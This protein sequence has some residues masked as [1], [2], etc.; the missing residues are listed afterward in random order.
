MAD[1]RTH[2]LQD[3]QALLNDREVMRALISASDAD[4][5]NNIIDLKSVVLKRLEGRLDEMEGQNSTIISAAY[6]NINTTTQVHRAI[7]NVLEP[8]SFTEFLD[9]LRGAWAQTVNV[10]VA[11][12][13]L[14]APAIPLDDMPALQREFGPGVVFLQ[15]DEIDYYITLGKDFEPRP[16][17]LR[18]I[19]KGVTKI[20]GTHAEG[21]RSEALMK[22]NLG[23]GN[24]PG[25]LLLG[26]NDATKFA[27]NMGTELLM[28]YGSVFEKVM[29][30]W[31][32]DD[33]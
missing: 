19:R 12:V 4:A 10:D 13:C 20:H 24:R 3:P 29:Q 15:R 9:F 25:L 14:E 30:R 5:S 21:V 32:Y 17:T 33:E 7:L 18:Q 23:A 31:L 1:I 16:I 8:K 11:R 22:L 26:S 27:P 2:I 28:F 6:D